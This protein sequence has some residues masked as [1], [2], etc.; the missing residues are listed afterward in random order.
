MYIAVLRV[1]LNMVKHI[2]RIYIY[3]YILIQSLEYISLRTTPKEQQRTQ[4]NKKHLKF[5]FLF[6]LLLSFV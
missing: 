2:Y 5:F 1:I 4:Q 6:L 3:I